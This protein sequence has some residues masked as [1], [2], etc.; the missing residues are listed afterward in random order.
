MKA[1]YT[2]TLS[3]FL[4]RNE[5]EAIWQ[6][7]VTK[8]DKFPTFSLQSLNFSMYD[9]FKE[10]YDIREI[11]AETDSLFVHFIND[12]LNEL[13]VKY[14]PKIALYV[15]N[16][17][18]LLDRKI[19]LQENSADTRVLDRTIGTDE[20]RDTKLN[21]INATAGVGSARTATRESFETDVDEDSTYTIQYYGTKEQA[22]MFFKSNPELLEKALEIRDVYLD[23]LNEFDP[24]F[25]G[26]F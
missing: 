15:N 24:C 13:L 25:M 7:I 1:L 14:A 11:G 12:K 21:P 2:E 20:N 8:F 19:T 5:D 4:A 16:F 3:D 23:A 6:A 10:K 18:N 22:L 26:I 9:L 17:A